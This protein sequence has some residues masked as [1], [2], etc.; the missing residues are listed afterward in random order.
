MVPEILALVALTLA[1]LLGRFSCA[2]SA[3]D[4][5]EQV[6]RERQEL[7][8]C[9]Q[10]EGHDI[11]LSTVPRDRIPDSIGDLC[12]GNLTRHRISLESCLGPHAGLVDECRTD[13]GDADPRLKQLLAQCQRES[14]EAE[15]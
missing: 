5:R 11:D 15:L 10:L 14:T 1:Q 4:G 12:G 2:G 7:D 9:P 6:W 13:H 3:C 8:A